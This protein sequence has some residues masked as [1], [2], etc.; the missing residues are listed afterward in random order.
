M[1]TV[2]ISEVGDGSYT[3]KLESEAPMGAEAETPGDPYPS[4]EDALAAVPAL[5]GGAG[6]EPANP[7]MEGEEDFVAGF[8][9]ARGGEGQGY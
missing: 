8:K 3:V 1:K 2:C 9:Q 7:P 5:F 6:S 4:L